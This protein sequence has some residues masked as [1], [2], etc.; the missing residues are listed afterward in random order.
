[1]FTAVCFLAR[2]LVCFAVFS[3][4]D[5][6]FTQVRVTAV[7]L[8]DIS[9]NTDHLSLLHII[10]IAECN[11]GFKS[12]TPRFWLLLYSIATWSLSNML[13]SLFSVY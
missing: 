5:Q 11:A 8:A 2:R 1:M 10:I 9:H 7:T 3:V 4:A 6:I 12:K 13:G